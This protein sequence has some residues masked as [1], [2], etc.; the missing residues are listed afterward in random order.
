MP[1]AKKAALI[2]AGWFEQWADATWAT[3]PESGKHDPALLR[4]PNGTIQDT[5]DALDRYVERISTDVPA[6]VAGGRPV[7][8]DARAAADVGSGGDD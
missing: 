2:P 8:G 3:D 7:G 4:A 5:R 1:E 6:P